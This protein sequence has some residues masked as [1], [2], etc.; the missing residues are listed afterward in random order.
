MF[1]FFQSMMNSGP[2]VSPADAVRAVADKRAVVV[3]VRETWEYARGHVPGARLISLGELARRAEELDPAAPVAVICATGGRSQSAAAL[4]GHPLHLEI[5]PGRFLVAEAGCL[6]GPGDVDAAAAL[7][8][9]LTDA[10]HFRQRQVLGQ[11]RAAQL[12]WERTAA[13]TLEALCE[14]AHG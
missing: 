14:A 12:T 8:G 7:V 13:L 2:A 11:A 10:A 9:A 1:N 3:D 6:F 5:E 4:L